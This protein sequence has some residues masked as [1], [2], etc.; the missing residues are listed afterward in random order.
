M[1]RL[2]VNFTISRSPGSS[3]HYTVTSIGGHLVFHTS[4]KVQRILCMM[5]SL[6]LNEE[7]LGMAPNLCAIP[8]RHILFQHLPVLPSNFQSVYKLAMF[9]IS[10][11]ALGGGVSMPP[12][13]SSIL[14]V[15]DFHT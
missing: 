12:P 8:S 4:N 13:L 11:S 7:F 9:I 5:L 2:A 3:R 1:R 10:P 6:N 14:L 15:A